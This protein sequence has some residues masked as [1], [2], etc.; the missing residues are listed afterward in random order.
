MADK[1]TPAAP[2][3]PDLQKQYEEQKA[4]V[5]AA[6]KKLT[7]ATKDLAT[8]QSTL[9]DLQ[10]RV[11]EI[12]QAVAGYDKTLQD[13]LDQSQ[14]ALGTKLKNAK[15]ALKDLTAKIDDIV[16]GF[17][18]DLSAQKD[19]V[20]KAKAGAVTAT[21][22]TD[23]ANATLQSAQADLD[24]EKKSPRTLN[25]GLQDLQSLLDQITKAEAQSDYVTVYFL[26]SEAKT[27]ADALGKIP[28]ADE[29]G[30]NLKAKESAVN[31]AKDDL[32]NKKAAATAAEDAYTKLQQKYEAASKSRQAD[33]VSALKAVHPKAA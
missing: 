11:N 30:T 27:K 17:D 19:A 10:T 15:D 23:K 31:N 25:A 28:T 21:G 20:D 12:N 33:I 16:T 18:K 9:Q 8:Q 5:D 2:A 14:K 24:A 1:P 13:R 32:K 29:Y 7:D 26:A 6:Q 4:A 22:D 3:A